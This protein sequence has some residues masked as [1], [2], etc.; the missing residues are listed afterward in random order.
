MKSN[1]YDYNVH[2]PSQ[3]DYSLGSVKYAISA[4]NHTRAIWAMIKDENK[5]KIFFK[6]IRSEDIFCIKKQLS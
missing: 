2:S 5:R 4:K 3:Q 1:S 6:S